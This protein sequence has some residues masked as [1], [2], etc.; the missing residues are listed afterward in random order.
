MQSPGPPRRRHHPALVTRQP[1]KVRHLRFPCRT[2]YDLSPPSQ[3]AQEAHSRRFKP[4]KLSSV[5][6]SSTKPRSILKKGAGTSSGHR[7]GPTYH[8]RTLE[9]RNHPPRTLSPPPSLSPPLRK[10]TPRFRGL[11][12]VTRG[13]EP[14][15]DI[16]ED[17]SSSVHHHHCM[18]SVKTVS[19]FYHF[20]LENT[21]GNFPGISGEISP[22]LRGNFPGIAG[23]FPRNRGEISPESQGN[24]PGI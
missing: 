17:R 1:S 20:P 7:G 4:L 24:F 3:A 9:V 18:R 2:I 19:T 8:M 21:P 23:K 12:A 15:P 5:V 14:R 11:A 13:Q 16:V 22:E 10:M 6:S